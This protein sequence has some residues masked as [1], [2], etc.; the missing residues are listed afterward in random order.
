M[1]PQDDEAG[2][3]G[4]HPDRS[5]TMDVLRGDVH[6]RY[7]KKTPDNPQLRRLALKAIAPIP[8]PRVAVT[9]SAP[10]L[11]NAMEQL[12]RIPDSVPKRVAR[13][14]VEVELRLDELESDQARAQTVLLIA[15]LGVPLILT[16][17]AAREGGKAPR[18]EEERQTLIAQ[19]LSQLKAPLAAG[20]LLDIEASSLATHPAGW[21]PVIEQAREK[22]L[23][24]MVSHHDFNATPTDVASLLPPAQMLADTPGGPPLLYKSA[25]KTQNWTQ[26][27]TIL[28]ASRQANLK[29]RAYALM[30][31]GRPTARL[32]APFF[33][34]PLVYAVPPGAPAV[35]PGQLSFTDLLDTWCRW[36]ITYQDE[37]LFSSGEDAAGHTQDGGPPRLAL[38][39]RPAQHSLS[40][41]MHNAALRHAG[42]PHR[43][44][45]LQPPNDEDPEAVLQETLSW[46]PE[47]GV[48]GG[49]A[50]SPFKPG[51]ARAADRLEGPAK[52]LSAANTYRF[53]DNV[54]VA[55]NTDPE[56]IRTPLEQTGLDIQDTKVLILGA[57]AAAAAAVT[58]LRDAAGITITNRTQQRATQL[59]T[60]LHD[61]ADCKSVEWSK[62]DDEAADATLIIQATLM[63]MQ[64]TPGEGENPL[65]ATRLTPEHTVYELVY[66]PRVTPLLAHA[67]KAGARTL[68]GLEML[69]AQ[70]AAAYRFWTKRE[71]PLGVM[72]D[73]VMQAETIALPQSVRDAMENDPGRTKDEPRSQGAKQPQGGGPTD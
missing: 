49:N 37:G 6:Q 18:N 68:D 45:P 3:P 11:Q 58:A 5:T 62:R 71:A 12:K 29:E 16:H 23:N 60:R 26:E 40:P 19:I 30:G 63:G 56:G 47:L 48:I 59:A 65:S 1:T 52:A 44:F 39:G 41:A 73:A 4:K 7:R 28:A 61:V 54:L 55:T 27:L 31:M 33:G 43:Y 20:S 17:R 38:L 14:P 36:G 10:T 8:M 21:K 13:H 66:A 70:G 22:G 35:A 2:K 69:L 53:D 34:S 67:K 32:L 72:R 15:R 25:T 42:L 9:I 46:L 24:L 50:T 51:L 57:G 64:G